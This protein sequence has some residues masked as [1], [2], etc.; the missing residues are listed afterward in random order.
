MTIRTRKDRERAERHQRIIDAARELAET[1]GWEAVTV[2]KLADRIEYS[3]PVLYSHFSGKTAIVTAV[4][5]QGFVELADL[6]HSARVAAATPAA[7]LAAVIATYLD[8][9][10]THP[11]RYDAMFLMRT[12]LVFGPAAP[13][14]LKACYAEIEQ[15]YAPFAGS[16]DVE[17]GTE[18]TWAAVHGLATLDQGARLR[19]DW[20]D[21]RMKVLF[22]QLT[23]AAD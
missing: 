3:Q 6:L 10:A 16:A 18:V 19:P 12:E 23:S 14:P 2:R 20:R 7:A 4:A 11:A 17:T 13:E 1:Q 21:E 15:A 22:A 8:F 9:A 5:E